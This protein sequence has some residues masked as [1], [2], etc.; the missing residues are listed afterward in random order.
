MATAAAETPSTADSK[1]RFTT[2]FIGGRCGKRCS[3]CASTEALAASATEEVSVVMETAQLSVLLGLLSRWM[4][5]LGAS[6]AMETAVSENPR[7]PALMAVSPPAEM[8][9]SLSSVGMG[10]LVVMTAV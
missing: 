2:S 8:A 5:R 7:D 1:H 9:L 3:E 10:V 4:E 6:A